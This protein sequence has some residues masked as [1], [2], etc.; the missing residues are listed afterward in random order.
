[1]R[2]HNNL[3][4]ILLLA[5]TLTMTAGCGPSNEAAEDAQTVIDQAAETAKQ[6]VAETEKSVDRIVG[7]AVQ[8]IR[9]L[10]E[11]NVVDEAEAKDQKD[12]SV[13]KLKQD[14]E[15]TPR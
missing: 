10:G 12:W 13:E 3:V 9:D 7:D 1:M 5:T 2:S 4:S 14:D 11:E 8:T 15:R 6:L